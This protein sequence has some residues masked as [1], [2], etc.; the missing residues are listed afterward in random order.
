MQFLYVDRGYGYNISILV[1]NK[2]YSAS[3]QLNLQFR[4]FFFRQKMFGKSWLGIWIPEV[5]L[6]F[7]VRLDSFYD[8]ISKYPLVII[9]RTG[10]T[11]KT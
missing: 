9:A 10:N 4:D 6:Q 8:E 3:H 5:H 7:I 2:W 11:C 1:G